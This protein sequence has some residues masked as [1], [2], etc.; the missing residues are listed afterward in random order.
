[1]RAAHWALK[2]IELLQKQKLTTDVLW[3]HLQHTNTQFQWW[4]CNWCYMLSFTGQCF[5]I[6]HCLHTVKQTWEAQIQQRLRTMKHCWTLQRGSVRQSQG[7]W[8]RW[9]LSSSLRTSKLWCFDMTMK[10]MWDSFLGSDQCSL[11]AAFLNLLQLMYVPVTWDFVYPSKLFFILNCVLRNMN[12]ARYKD[13]YFKHT[14]FIPC[15]EVLL[16]TA[17]LTYFRVFQVLAWN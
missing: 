3:S 9:R 14:Q 11:R 6:H 13:S 1:M 2:L 7:D 12:I 15:M 10:G 5:Q 4:K 8:P 16:S 17:R